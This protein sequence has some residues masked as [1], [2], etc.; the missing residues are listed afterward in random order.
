MRFIACGLF[1]VSMSKPLNIHRGSLHRFDN[2][3]NGQ[4]IA[5]WEMKSFNRSQI[6]YNDRRFRHIVNGI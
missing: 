6:I 5:L 1:S 4:G 2:P 3:V